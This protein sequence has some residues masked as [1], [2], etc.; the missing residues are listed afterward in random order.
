MHEI[1]I[2][3]HDPDKMSVDD[4]IKEI[5]RILAVGFN[6]LSISHQNPRN[7]LDDVDGERPDGTRP[8]SPNMEVA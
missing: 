6:R 5:S 1:I 2:T 7:Q 8:E 4:R 3:H